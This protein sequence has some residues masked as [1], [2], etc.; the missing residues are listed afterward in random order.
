MNKDLR[1]Q[2]FSKVGNRKCFDCGEENPLWVSLNNSIL[3]CKECQVQH[4]SYGISVSY[5]KSIELDFWKEDQIALLK[6][7][8]NDRLRELM[9]L[10]SVKQSTDRHQLYYSKLLDYYRR[11]LRAELKNETRP[12]P[13]LD[14][15]ALISIEEN[16][17][18]NNENININPHD[19]YNKSDNNFDYSESNENVNKNTNSGITGYFSTVWNKTLDV[20]SDVKNQIDKTGITEKLKDTTN[21]VITKAK[22]GGSEVTKIG[23]SVVNTG[24]EYAL[25]GVEYTKHKIEDVV[26]LFIL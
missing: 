23:K 2:I 5:I 3:L 24:T 9:S 12:V 16:S 7:G 6:S 17:D 19:D 10:Y 11:L 21:Y 14:E 22:E 25:S 4:R 18:K 13:P 20:A 1:E 8:G 15:E 26:S